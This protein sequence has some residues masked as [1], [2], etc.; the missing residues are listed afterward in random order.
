[1]TEEHGHQDGL[2]PTIPPLW[3][4]ALFR[5]MLALFAVVSSFAMLGWNFLEVVLHDAE[6]VAASVLD[7]FTLS[8]VS[9]LLLPV[10]GF[11]GGVLAS[12]S[13][14]ILPLV[15]LNIA[16]VGA[17]EATGWRS[18]GLSLRFVAGAA[19][20]LSLLGIFGDLAGLLLVEHRGIMLLVVGC[21]LIYFGLVVSE[22][23]PDLFR[24]RGLA[25]RQRLG[26][27]GTGA[28]F[29][30]VTTPCSSPILGA[31]LAAAAAHSVPGLG[32]ATMISFSLGY[33][34]LVFLGGLFGGGL[35]AWASRLRLEAPRA[36]AAALLIVSGF[37]LVLTGVAWF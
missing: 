34:L 26:P 30:M 37:T 17:H 36:V 32:V 20:V 24:G 27:F 8:G 6:F 18:L 12:F 25:I 3:R 4:H 16:Y 15:P 22:A 2:A 1:M 28:A 5:W 23:A 9:F 31:V 11:G 14:C 19:A 13:P 10:V 35:V 29:S 7:T 33:T 21:A